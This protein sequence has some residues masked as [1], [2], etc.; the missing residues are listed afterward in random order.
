MTIAFF[1]F[2]YFISTITLSVNHIA[3]NMF[4]LQIV[5]SVLCDSFDVFGNY[6]VNNKIKQAAMQ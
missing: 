5:V 6:I 3:G 1:L 4:I 2:C